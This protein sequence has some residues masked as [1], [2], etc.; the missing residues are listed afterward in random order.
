MF[1][2]HVVGSLLRPAK[3]IAAREALQR[4]GIQ[5]SEFKR[6]EDAAVDRAIQL[7]EEAGIELI[8]DGEQRRFL[9][10][11]SF[12]ASV[13]GI[14]LLANDDPT[15]RLWHDHE[16]RAAKPPRPTFMPTIVGRISRRNS[17]ATEE[18]SYVRAR[19]R[20][21]VK[22]T[23]PSPTCALQYWSETKSKVAYPSAL[24][25]LHDVAAVLREEIAS[26]AALG[27]EHVQIDAP[28]LTMAIDADS[29]H[30]Y[31]QAG[32]TRKSFVAEAMGL[33]NI[34]AKD[35]PVELSVHLC[36]GNN[37]G[38]W[39]SKG[40][41]EAISKECF[42]HL[43]NFTYVLLEYDD[44]RSGSFAALSDMPREC[45]VVLGLVSTKRPEVEPIDALLARTKEAARYFPAAQIGISPQC[46]FAS[47]LFG[48]PIGID[49]Q[50]A[51]LRRVGEAGARLAGRAAG[52]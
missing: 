7:Q 28:E 3:L 30:V 26:L 20:R 13:A 35:S 33:L 51:K 45:N 8:T 24:A 27:C 18:F 43:R 31:E 41:Y 1:H 12:G 10:T 4:R 48:N 47:A 49:A 21:P 32:F 36:R 38:L 5:A 52:D 9:F 25:A 15:E 44:E 17:L 40:G 23:L 46:G 19:A 22:L 37:Q 42:P 34:V 14:E 16:G 39:H 11:D 50:T 29:S 2:A 6:L